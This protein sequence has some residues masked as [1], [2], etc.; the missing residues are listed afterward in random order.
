ME[1]LSPHSVQN[2]APSHDPA[3]R[4]QA[5]HDTL[6]RLV[7]DLTDAG[8]ASATSEA[9]PCGRPGPTP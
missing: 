3:R 8:S 7:R 9:G 4:R 2:P 5:I 6:D 1:E